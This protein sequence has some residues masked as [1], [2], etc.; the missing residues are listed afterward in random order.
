MISLLHEN[1]INSVTNN[2]QNPHLTVRIS[3]LLAAYGTNQRF[4]KVW[5][6]NHS[7]IIARLDNSFY[8]YAP[9]GADY[10]ELAVFF[11]AANGALTISGQSDTIRKIADFI[12]SPFNITYCNIAVKSNIGIYNKLDI[13][14]DN[15]P[16]LELV[17]E[18]LKS[19]ENTGFTVGEFNSW[20]VDI[21]H[22]IRHGCGRAYLINCEQAAAC[23]LVE[24]QS[25]FAGLI[26]GVA[27]KP[28][29]RAKA[30]ATA[31]VS[32]ASEVLHQS[33]RIPVL[34]CSDNMLPFYEK[35][36]FVKVDVGASLGVR[37]L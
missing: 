2:S 4:F 16:R 22:R 12:K 37:S 34:E 6:H 28:Q 36:G 32:N 33:G 15:N 5:E 20:Y 7:C 13:E 30:F 18:V 35:M 25:G 26:S 8:V 11:C 29:F 31:L 27:V 24:A 3:A 10:E 19:C 23:C 21:S 1:K 17:Y 14:I 9:Q